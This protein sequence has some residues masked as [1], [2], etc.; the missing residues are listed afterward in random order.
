MARLPST[1]LALP[2]VGS[3]SRG[4]SHDAERASCRIR[5][6]IASALS[7]GVSQKE[8]ASSC[9]TKRAARQERASSPLR[10]N[11]STPPEGTD[12]R[13][14]DGAPGGERHASF[15][16]AHLNGGGGGGRVGGRDRHAS[17][18]R[19]ALAANN[20]RNGLGVMGA[21][22]RGNDADAA[23]SGDGS[24]RGDSR[25][26]GT[27][28]ASPTILGGSAGDRMKSLQGPPRSPPAAIARCAKKWNVVQ[29][30]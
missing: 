15:V 28:G 5:R 6:S 2:E 26:G 7:R 30:V 24:P 3:L 27:R 1:Y 16:A 18:G 19:A 14:G 4:V 22:V 20:P 13:S 23:R 12:Y 11:R 21:S 25:G 8:S 17:N 10:C 9:R 29:S